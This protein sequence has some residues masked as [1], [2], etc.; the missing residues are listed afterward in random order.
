MNLL[1]YHMTKF[2]LNLYFTVHY[3][4][5]KISGFTLVLFMAIVFSSF[6]LVIFCF[7]EFSTFSICCKHH[8]NFSKLH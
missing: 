3:C 1:M 2:S 8:L 5:P 4:Y 7:V 6:Q